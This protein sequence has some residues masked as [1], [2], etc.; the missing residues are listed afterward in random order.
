MVPDQ[1]AEKRNWP[2]T[3][4]ACTAAVWPPCSAASTADI[5]KLPVAG[6]TC[7]QHPD[8]LISEG[9]R[10]YSVKSTCCQDPD[11]RVSEGCLLALILA[12]AQTEFMPMTGA[13]AVLWWLH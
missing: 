8:K 3:V 13:F 12:A 2:E 6:S 11:K 4:S 5:V 9:F 7:S 1:S 10:V